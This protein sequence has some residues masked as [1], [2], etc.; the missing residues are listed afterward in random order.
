MWIDSQTLLAADPESQVHPLEQHLT[1]PS[2][3]LGL[4]FKPVRVRR[5]WLRAGLLDGEPQQ[6]GALGGAVW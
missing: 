2:H 1:S 3:A 4:Q 5:P 6:L